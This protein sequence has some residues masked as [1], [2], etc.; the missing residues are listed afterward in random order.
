[1]RN[2]NIT[3]VT[4]EEYNMMLNDPVGWLHQMFPVGALVAFTM[5]EFDGDLPSYEAVQLGSVRAVTYEDP[6]K[7]NLFRDKGFAIVIEDIAEDMTSYVREINRI[8]VIPT[9]IFALQA[10][11]QKLSQHERAKKLRQITQSFADLE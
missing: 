9:Y 4:Q 11:N 3:N 5:E 2:P 10:Q 1:M 7:V 8:V 6:D